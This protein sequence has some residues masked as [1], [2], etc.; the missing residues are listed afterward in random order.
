MDDDTA[1][2]VYKFINSYGRIGRVLKQLGD[3]ESLPVPLPPTGIAGLP[4]SQISPSHKETLPS[5]SWNSHRL[6]KIGNIINDRILGIIHTSP[7]NH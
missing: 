6:M 4:S 3:D 5:L 2:C 7:L 1:N